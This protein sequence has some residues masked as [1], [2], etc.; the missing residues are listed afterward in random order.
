MQ[1]AFIDL[2]KI[3]DARGN[4]S[5]LESENHIPFEIKRAYWIYGVP[6]G[7]AR[8][9]LAFRKSQ[10]VIIALSGSFE[11]VVKDG[12]EENRYVLNRSYHAVQVP[13]LHWRSLE[14][15]STN[16]LAIILASTTYDENDYIRDYP[17]FL[18]EVGVE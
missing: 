16:S 10:E 7:E 15:F 1:P 4:L 9:N 18:Q 14:N 3:P 5:F 12:T 11:V 6:G 13:N 2:P 8:G 17:E